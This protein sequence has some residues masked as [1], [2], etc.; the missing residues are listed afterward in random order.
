[1]RS[2]KLDGAA[3]DSAT[4]AY[5]SSVASQDSVDALGFSLVRT[6]VDGARVVALEGEIDLVNADAVEH[7]L[8][9]LAAD[10]GPRVC[11]DLCGVSFMD[12]SALAALIKGRQ[13]VI[14]AGGDFAVACIPGPVA[15]IL[16]VTG[17]DQIMRVAGSREDAVALLA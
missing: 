14:G 7:A 2:R 1:M 17:L 12:S 10:G 16:D 4:P 9:E 5:N 6:E 8:I 15:R 3:H 13:R 11:V